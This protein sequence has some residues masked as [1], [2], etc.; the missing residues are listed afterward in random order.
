MNRSVLVATLAL[1]T[2][3]GAASPAVAQTATWDEVCTSAVGPNF[4]GPVCLSGQLT[5][6]TA[7]GWANLWVWNLQG[8]PGS[9]SYVGSGSVI[10]ALGLGGLPFDLANGVSGYTVTNASGADVPPGWQLVV[11]LAG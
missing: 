10:D 11:K 2:I 3:G 4:G 5:Y 8:L 9:G 7:D 6:N 1:A